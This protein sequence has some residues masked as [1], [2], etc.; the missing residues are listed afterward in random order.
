VWQSGEEVAGF[1][2]DTIN[3]FSMISLLGSTTSSPIL[4]KL[5]TLAFII[6]YLP[7]ALRGYFNEDDE[8][9]GDEQVRKHTDDLFVQMVAPLPL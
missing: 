9:E 4:L 5:T 7:L 8:D 2:I 6:G 3:N 1:D